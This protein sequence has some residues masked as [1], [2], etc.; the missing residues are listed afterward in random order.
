MKSKTLDTMIADL[1]TKGDGCGFIRQLAGVADQKYRDAHRCMMN[2]TEDGYLAP[3]TT[4]AKNHIAEQRDAMAG[5]IARFGNMTVREY[6]HMAGIEYNEK[7]GK[8][9]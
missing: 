5:F 6:F 2:A 3:N 9:Q 4:M 7:R 8:R 1:P